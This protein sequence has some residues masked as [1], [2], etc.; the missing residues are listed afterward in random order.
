MKLRTLYLLL[1]VTI[2][3]PVAVFSGMAFAMLL[4]SQR[5]AATRRIEETARTTSMVIEAD[6]ER[7]RAVLRVLSN[8]H[9]LATGQL[10]R[11]YDEA[12]VANAGP[13]A[14]I[15]LYDADGGQLINTRLDFGAPRLVRPDVDAM[16]RMMAAGRDTVSGLKW[17]VALKNTFVMIEHPFVTSTGTRHVI[18]QAFAPSYFARAF[19]DR[20]IPDS[21]RMAVIDQHGKIIARS[22]RTTTFTG[23]EANPAVLAAA[24]GGTS[25]AFRHETAD[26]VDA[27]DYFVRSPSS[28]WTIVVSAPVAEVDAAVWSSMW[29]ALCGLVLAI[30]A[31][32]GLAILSGRRLLRFVGRASAVAHAL[33]E[34][35]SA[36][37]APS[38][39]TEMEEL[40]DALR[41]AGTRL[42]VEM[43]SREEAVQ[44]RNE[45]LLLERSAR[46]HAEGQNAAKDEFLA[47][48]G[49]ELRNPLSAITSAVTLLDGDHGATVADKARAVLRRQSA[50][51]GALVDDLLEV[52]RAL[53]GKL[54][55]HREPLDLAQVARLCV[56]TLQ[57]AGRSGKCTL[58]LL[59][60][61]GPVPVSADRT[62]LAQVV[63]N[64]LDNAI[65]YSPDGGDIR[66]AVHVRDGH[67][68]LAVADQ[69]A[70]I[71]PELLPQVFNVF[72]QGEQTLQRAQGGL[73]IGLTLA[74]RLVEMHGG[75]IAIA[76][77][78]VGQGTTVEIRLP[79]AAAATAAVTPP[80]VP[81]SAS[82][83]PDRSP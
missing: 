82:R 12:E 69:G 65:K 81:Q 43:R 61:A 50:H 66:V 25:G 76:S 73:G 58:R 36:Q 68:E 63:D 49:H 16:K 11:F 7:A 32:L 40:N 64:V 74:R 29:V 23:R 46:E 80:P 14:W 9:A 60:V 67:A 56:E 47:M 27:Y 57:A 79:L 8:S 18:G 77:P 1:A 19:T 42:A 62:R 20:A 54:S 13:G 52:N 2:V 71:A 41:E 24:R 22:H 4:D 72:V 38:S 48:L 28:G 30:G 37:L 15:I 78:G 21:W 6:I 44:A 75:T 70:G 59:P 53:M 3:A 26:G 33:G 10:S 83:S 34:G 51:L 5:D 55:L 45:A 35:K 17:G 39:I 31:A